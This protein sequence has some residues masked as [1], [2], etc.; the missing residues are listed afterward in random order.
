MDYKTY[1]EFVIAVENKTSIQSLKYF[2]RL[3]NIDN[4]NKLSSKTI[5][6]INL[7]I[8]H[9]LNLFTHSLAAY[10][11]NEIYD[12]LKKN[13]YDAPPVDD[14]VSEIFD[15][16]GCQYDSQPDFDS[17]VKSGQGHVV[18]SML[19]DAYA[20][21]LYDNRESLVSQIPSNSTS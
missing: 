14:V 9:L 8:T 2:W 12:T 7:I 17:I 19:L 15:I 6:D 3:F 21:Y 18:M 1:V 10:F 16:L 4:N 11:Y 5:G 20:F 13:G